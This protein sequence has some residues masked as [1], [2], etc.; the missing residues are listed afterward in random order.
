M[1]ITR[2][3]TTLVPDSYTII[4]TMQRGQAAIANASSSGTA[5][6]SSVDMAKATLRF[7]GFWTDDD[8]GAGNLAQFPHIGL[9][10]ATTVTATRTSTQNAASLSF[11]V[12]EKP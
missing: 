8:S 4:K 11:E 9:T 1:A 7:L 3:F 5:T 2:S 10:N 12:D 6:I